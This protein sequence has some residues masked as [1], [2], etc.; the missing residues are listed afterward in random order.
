MIYKTCQ[1]ENLDKEDSV[2]TVMVVV[3]VVALVVQDSA[4]LLHSAQPLELITIEACSPTVP[5]AL[6]IDSNNHW[7]RILYT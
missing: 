6:H 5:I 1:Q 2:A 3:V 4:G 7:N